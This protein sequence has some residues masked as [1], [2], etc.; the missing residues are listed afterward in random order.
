MSK[1]LSVVSF[2]RLSGVVLASLVFMEI[3]IATEGSDIRSGFQ[4]DCKASDIIVEEHKNTCKNTYNA[5]TTADEK[6][7]NGGAAGIAARGKNRE[8]SLKFCLGDSRYQ[9]GVSAQCAGLKGS[10][11]QDRQ[12]KLVEE[13]KGLKDDCQKSGGGPL[14]SCLGYGLACEEDG[15]RLGNKTTVEFEEENA[16]DWR[17]QT[18][19]EALMASGNGSCPGYAMGNLKDWQE[20]IKDGTRRMVEL[21]RDAAV[22]QKK[23]MENMTSL[24]QEMQKI[25]EDVQR[26][27]DQEKNM[28]EELPEVMKNIDSQTEAQIQDMSIK[29][30][31][32]QDKILQINDKLRRATVEY[33]RAI[34]QLNAACEAEG[35]SQYK[36]EVF[37]RFRNRPNAGG[38]INQLANVGKKMDS[39]QKEMITTACSQQKTTSAKAIAAQSLAA[40]QLS[41]SEAAAQVKELISSS[42]Q[43][44][45]AI[46]K[47]G[48]NQKSM[49]LKKIESKSRD[50]NT[51]KQVL[52]TKKQQL[53]VQASQRTIS[54]GQQLNIT[55]EE[56]QREALRTHNATTLAGLA[57][58]KGI[59]RDNDK[60][61]SNED[62]G[63]VQQFE[64][65]VASCEFIR[66][67]CS[68]ELSGEVKTCA[69]G[70]PDSTGA[71]RVG[72]NKKSR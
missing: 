5:A 49:A 16:N 22:E 35:R 67:K 2:L 71:P 29:I 53:L 69:D 9:P 63:L 70:F 58:K 37:D 7:K 38:S 19:P 36:T 25:D 48:Q 55:Q 3:G 40:D 21:K 33:S 15:K 26:L 32:E 50:I 45:D 44:L 17:V 4:P 57:R 27:S 61:S 72:S 34:A 30:K 51:Q 47:M 46:F 1:Y 18:D 24:Q 52:I 10:Q 66:G 11:C 56:L 20:Q 28:L 64:G 43:N 31:Q 23:L 6:N 8:E 60:F 12:E 39:I 54:D 14:G 68:S 59:N 41:L 62:Y 13:M 65:L 42:A